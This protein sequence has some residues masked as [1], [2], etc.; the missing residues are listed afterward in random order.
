MEHSHFYRDTAVEQV[1]E[2]QFRANLVEGW[3]IGTVP[4][5]GYVLAIAGRA[6]QMALPHPDPLTAHI[7]YVAPALL[8]P[9]EISVE[10]LRS[11][12]STSHGLLKLSQEGEVRVVVTASYTELDRLRGENW[13]V[14]ERP[15][16]APAQQCPPFGE[17]GVELRRNVNQ[18][19]TSGDSALRRQP[20]DGSGCF[21]GW[22]SLAD[23]TAPDPLTLLLFADA[24]PP[25]AFTVVGPTGWVPTVDLSVQLRRRPVPGPVQVQFRMRHLSDGVMEE[26]GLLW[27]SDGNLVAMS[28]QLAKIRVPR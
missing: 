2:G 8:G 15:E 12:G 20:P 27:D 28:R 25:P 26:D 21:N 6:L 3:R 22:I 4:N 1:G 11:G 14:L 18:C 23:G 17:H 7:L 9:A 10:V 16:I 5:G 24:F 19:I 13:S